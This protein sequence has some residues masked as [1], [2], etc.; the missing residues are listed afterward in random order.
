MFAK[1]IHMTLLQ[2]FWELNV[3]KSA[4]SRQIMQLQ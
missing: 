1:N 4:E 2:Y 3:S